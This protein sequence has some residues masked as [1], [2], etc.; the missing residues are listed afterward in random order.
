[1]FTPESRS[2]K[3]LWEKLRHAFAVGPTE[4]LGE[5]DLALLRDVAEKIARRGLTTPALLALHSVQPLG[6]ISG[7]VL[8]ASQPFLE[9][10]L[11]KEKLERLGRILERRDAIETFLRCLELGARN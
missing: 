11:P 6:Y 5:E 3:V 9:I 2:P 1:L 8:I 7:Q 10:V 4:P